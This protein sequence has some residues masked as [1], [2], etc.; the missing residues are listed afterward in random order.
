[1]TEPTTSR[2][3]SSTPSGASPARRRARWSCY[4][5]DEL[6]ALRRDER[7]RPDPELSRGT[8]AGHVPA[9]LPSAVAVLPTRRARSRARGR[10]LSRAAPRLVR[11][12]ARATAAAERRRARG[13]LRGPHALRRAARTSWT[14]RSAGRARR[15]RLLSD[16]EKSEVLDAHPAIGASRLSARS[17]AEQGGGEDPAVLAELAELN[18]AYEEKF[19]FRFVVFVNR[20]PKRELVPVLR[21][22][23]ER[24][25]EE[26]LGDGAER[27]RRDRRGSMA[28]GMMRPELLAIDSYW[29]EW[30]NLL[31]RW[32]HVIAGIAWIGASFYFIA[33][34]NHL[35]P[36]EDRATRRGRRRRGLGGPRRRLLPRAQVPGRAAERCPSRCTGSSGRRTRP[37][38]PASRCSSSSTTSTPTRRSIDPSVAD[39]C[40]AAEAIALSVA[41]ARARVGRLRRAL[42]RARLVRA[43]ARVGLSSSRSSPLSRLRRRASS[44]RARAAYLQVGAMLGTIM[45]GERLLRDHPGAL[46]AD[47][48]EGGGPR[49]GSGARDCA[50]KQRSVHN[51]YLTLP[52]V[53]AMISNHFPF[54]YGHD[55]RLARPRRADGDRRLD[56]ALLQP[57]PRRP[58]RLVDP[59]HRRGRDRG[60]RRRRSARTTAASTVPARSRAVR[61]GAGDRRSS[62]ARRATREH[63]TQHWLL[64]RRRPGSCSTRAQQIEQRAD[65]IEALAVQTK[66]DAARQRDRA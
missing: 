35:L 39:I 50:A 55:A 21:E 16:E 23:L 54:T 60:A 32:L 64:A 14:T 66:R 33:L 28:A 57:A 31:F 34:D 49:A 3:T 47:P 56:P 9:R 12:R 52:V 62:A 59:G 20:R 18:R 43:A 63:P 53:F 2:P 10:P 15:R 29:L 37:G 24:T 26:E 42:P 25:R 6:V 46:G 36:P 11:T 41:R 45:V 30:G 4:R 38:S 8:R 27:A 5:G 65:A 48:R 22:R 17:A 44:S 40:R 19:G 1:M 61:P 51:N 58:R 7:R 13:A